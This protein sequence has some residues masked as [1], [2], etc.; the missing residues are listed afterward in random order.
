LVARFRKRDLSFELGRRITRSGGSVGIDYGYDAVS[1]LA[2][3]GQRFPAT[4][5]NLFQSFA[6]NPASQVASETKDNDAY[7]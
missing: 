5:N 3:L 4:R 6:Y 1:R 7:A 2:T